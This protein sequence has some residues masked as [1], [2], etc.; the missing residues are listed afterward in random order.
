[1][2]KEDTARTSVQSSGIG[3]LAGPTAI[4][5]STGSISL[6]LS[7]GRF[8]YSPSEVAGDRSMVPGNWRACVQTA[9]WRFDPRAGPPLCFMESTY[10]YENRLV[11]RV[12]TSKGL[13][14]ATAW[15]TGLEEATDF[16]PDHRVVQ[17]PVAL[18]K[19]SQGF[20]VA[21]LTTKILLRR[22]A[23]PTAT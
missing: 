21:S 22:M 2:P 11:S 20:F 8:V 6:N 7:Q 18:E 4:T 16:K 19:I 3:R 1:M 13:L 23:L 12:Q 9:D 17:L 14:P 5:R 15:P 10:G